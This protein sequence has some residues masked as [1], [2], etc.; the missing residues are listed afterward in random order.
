M[1]L[2]LEQQ[3]IRDKC[4]HPTGTFVEFPMEDV[5]TSI[6]A[7]FEKIARQYPNRIG[8]KTR[9]QQLTYF[10]LSDAANRLADILLA[11][12]GRGQ[13]PIGLLFPKGIPLIVSIL[14]T[15]KAGKICVP[16]D[17]T[18]PQSRISHMLENA[19]VNLIVTLG[20]YLPMAKAFGQPSQC[21]NID[22]LNYS[23]ESKSPDISVGPDDFAYIFYTSGS[24]DLPKGVSEN[25]RNLL[26]HV[27]SETNDYRLC[28]D[29]RLIFI[30]ASGRDV[31]RALLNGACVYPVDIKHEGLAGLAD[32]LIQDEITILTG[33]VTV[34]RYFVATLN[35]TEKFPHLRLIKLVG[36]M[37]QSH[38]VELYRKYFSNDCILVNSYGPNEAGHV[39]H[40]FIDKT[41]KLTTRLVAVGHNV[42]GKDV[43]L[44]DGDG[45]EVD[46]GT[47]GEITVRSR[48]L[49]PG[50]WRR[51][52]LT[53]AKFRPANPDLTERLYFTGDLGVRDP[54]GCLTVIGRQ[55]FQVKIR[56]NRVEIS[57]VESALIDLES[58]K[59]AVVVA[60][61]D[62]RGEKR[63]VAY[64]VPATQPGPNVT[65]LLKQLAEKLPQYMIPSVFVSLDA[66]PVIGI[67]KVN[68]QAL[69][70]PGQSRP[71]LDPPFTMPRS[72]VENVLVQIWAEVL[73]LDR[74][75][76]HDNF[77]DLGGHSLAAS[78][79]VSRVIKNFRL[80]LPIQS[81][82]QSPTVAEMA[83]IIMQNQ[84]KPASDV[85][86][87]QML[88]EVE[89][90]SEEEAQ[91][92][93]AG[94]SARGPTGD[95]DE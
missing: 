48:Y 45:R 85:E 90:M 80:E 68:R 7:R 60:R 52:D 73:S 26:F 50:Y 81:L 3:A 14:G 51:P 37:V 29:D 77:F 49:S 93:L 56:G 89:A 9:T 17:P 88:H 34:F 86:L 33:V 83:A 8:V 1:K 21:F 58:V 79:V 40:Y 59:E 54:D 16:L 38:D 46:S 87:A 72:P 82:F 43:I 20:D 84:A 18:L 32:W 23:G 42:D 62:A 53:H 25:H 30:A 65:A 74:V 61:E 24:T 36:E 66:L 95:R 67:G 28:A 92:L 41:T 13:K 39:A 70:D 19:Q 76:I 94:V 31:L 47:I 69:P 64:V 15:L 5:E 2:P 4:F 44:V 10:E 71:N 22:E 91:K 27:K 63:L 75:G 78:R 35:G 6:P 55:D 11:Q 12:S 57:E